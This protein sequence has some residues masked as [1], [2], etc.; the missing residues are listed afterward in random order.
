MLHRSTEGS[1]DAPSAL[2]SPAFAAAAAEFYRVAEVTNGTLPSTRFCQV[3]PI[4]TRVPLG[5]ACCPCAVAVLVGLSCARPQRISP[6]AWQLDL[7]LNEWPSS[8]R[9]RSADESFVY[10]LYRA[11]RKVC[12]GGRA[13]EGAGGKARV[14]KRGWEGAGVVRA[15]RS[16][17]VCHSVVMVVLIRGVCVPGGPCGGARRRRAVARWR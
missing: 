9:P 16:E 1:D 4:D 10:V 11:A 7:R 6:R 17:G 12:T 14:R 15:T 2:T 5:A 8:V 13:Q 3:A